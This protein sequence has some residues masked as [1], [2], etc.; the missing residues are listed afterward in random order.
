MRDRV[1]AHVRDVDRVFH[2]HSGHRRQHRR[3]L[4][5]PQ[6]RVHD[7]NRLGVRR[8]DRE[9]RNL[10]VQVRVRLFRIGVLDRV[11]VLVEDR[12]VHRH[13]VEV[14][15]SVRHLWRGQLCRR[16]HGELERHEDRFVR[17]DVP[18]VG[19]AARP[20]WIFHH[21]AIVPI[22]HQQVLHRRLADV[23]DRHLVRHG[24]ARL[25]DGAQRRL[26]NQQL[27]GCDRY[28]ALCAVSHLRVEAV[29]QGS[30]GFHGVDQRGRV[31]RL[32]LVSVRTGR[33]STERQSPHRVTG[34]RVA[35]IAA[36]RPVALGRQVLRR[37]HPKR[38][39]DHHIVNRVGLVAVA[40]HDPVG[41]RIAHKGH[42]A[43]SRLRR[44]Q[45]R[46][47][48]IDPQLVL[49]IERHAVRGQPFHDR[50]VDDRVA[51]RGIQSAPVRAELHKLVAIQ[52]VIH[53][54]GRV[55]RHNR[56]LE[57][58]LQVGEHR[59]HDGDIAH[60]RGAVAQVLHL[61]A[62][63]N[64]LPDI[65]LRHPVSAGH[66]QFV[67]QQHTHR[68]DS[69]Q[70][71]LVRAGRRSDCLA[72]RLRY[73]QV[74]VHQVHRCGDGLADL[75]AL[76]AVARQPR[77][78]RD[79]RQRIRRISRHLVGDV[80][81]SEHFAWRQSQPLPAVVPRDQVAN[82]VIHKLDVADDIRADV[83]DGVVVQNRIAGRDHLHVGRLGQR[84]RR[85]R[86]DFHL[87]RRP[88]VVHEPAGVRELDPHD[89][90]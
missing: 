4:Q 27:A 72:R 84:K 78:R 52:Q 26:A 21:R 2:R 45:V 73:H 70:Q 68:R 57:Q 79:V 86:L 48:Q 83:D 46:P 64:A 20:T 59:V 88:Q 76:P 65:R 53:P 43:R 44:Q 60:I 22:H 54:V 14:R 82:F 15:V 19:L 33:I 75:S 16:R 36:G 7:V 3:R 80:R 69:R 50:F 24:I 35:R 12:P 89:V 8:F 81:Q 13:L 49:V 66:R 6:V 42:R 34:H 63:V 74:R 51:H 32:D 29:L 85:T 56:V 23:G 40:H 37:A 10:P 47:L 38:I 90:S 25:C 87:V 9:L 41:D 61:E 58:G 28:R 11:A 31:V 30:G 17:V 55:F 39:G 5:H 62:V 67:R 18:L 1:L 77:D 71:H